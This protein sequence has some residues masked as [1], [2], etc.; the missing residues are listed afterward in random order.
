MSRRRNPVHSKAARF[1]YRTVAM[2]LLGALCLGGLSSLGAENERRDV[3]VVVRNSD[4]KTEPDSDAATTSTLRLGNRVEVSKL[5]GRWARVHPPDAEQG[6]IPAANVRISMTRQQSGGGG[7]AKGLFRG[8]TGVVTGAGPSQDPAPS[9]TVGIRGL[10][11]EDVADAVPNPAERLKLDAYRA[12]PDAAERYARE[13]NLD[14]RSLAYFDDSGSTG[15]EPQSADE[16]S[17]SQD[18]N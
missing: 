16:A 2:A 17:G 15:N 18:R 11:P 14:S 3:G 4:V 8:I 1:T 5:R 6:W 13:E 7:A 12:T 10:T 9:A